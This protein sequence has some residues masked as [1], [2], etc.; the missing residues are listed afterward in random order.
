MPDA[1]MHISIGLD[2]GGTVG[3]DVHK[4]GTCTTRLDAKHTG[5]GKW[6]KEGNH[7]MLHLPDASMPAYDNPDQLVFKLGDRT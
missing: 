6:H 2:N 4:N 7:L 5:M 1:L 3:I